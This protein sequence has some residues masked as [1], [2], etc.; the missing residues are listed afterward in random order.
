[1]AKNKIFGLTSRLL[2]V[3]VA[4]LLALSYLSILVNPAKVWFM[5]LFGLLFVPLSIVNVILLLWAVKRRSKSF[6]IPLLALVP[7][8]FF[9]GRYVRVDTDEEREERYGQADQTLK[10]VSY[11]VGRFALNSDRHGIHGR[12]MCSDSVFRF[13]E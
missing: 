7:A 6:V 2:M 9:V 4:G 11:N 10:V 8:F 13:L 5:S 3:I 1:M 12:Q